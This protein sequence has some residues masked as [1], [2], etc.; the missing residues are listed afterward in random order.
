MVLE[1]QGWL[2]WVAGLGE[3]VAGLGDQVLFVEGRLVGLVLAVA[4]L[5]AAAALAPMEGAEPGCP[6][7]DKAGCT[8]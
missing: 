6:S 7:G 4:S 2:I 1:G 3:W 8:G 5:L